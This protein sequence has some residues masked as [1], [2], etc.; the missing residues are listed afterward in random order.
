MLQDKLYLDSTLYSV[1][2]FDLF[3]HSFNYKL[4]KDFKH[5]KWE[6][7]GMFGFKT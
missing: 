1:H 3:V 6:C 4:L 7:Q 2:S 5:S